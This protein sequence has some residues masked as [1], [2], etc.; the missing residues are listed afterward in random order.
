MHYT[1]YTIYTIHYALYTIHYALCTMH[2][3]LYTIHHTLYTMHYTLYTIHYTLYTTLNVGALSVAGPLLSSAVE[4]GQTPD[5]RRTPA[6]VYGK[7]CNP[8][9]H[10]TL[11]LGAFLGAAYQTSC[12]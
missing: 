11:S 3:A 10:L 4:D 1:L 5:A 2:Y 7:V 8:V 6:E 12:G 9:Y